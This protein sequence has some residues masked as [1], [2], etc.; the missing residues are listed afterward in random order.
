MHKRW[1]EME[2]V[3]SKFF[4]TAGSSSWFGSDYECDGMR[5]YAGCS[6]RRFS[7]LLSCRLLCKAI[8][9]PRLIDT[10]NVDP[11]VVR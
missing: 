1:P 3:A 11:Q 7:E 6:A 10:A 5:W 4:V 2:V 8:A 9:L